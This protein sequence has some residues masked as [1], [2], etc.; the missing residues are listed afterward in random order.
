MHSKTLS[1]PKTL[2]DFVFSVVK[3]NKPGK[4]HINRI[5]FVLNLRNTEGKIRIFTS[6]ATKKTV[7]MVLLYLTSWMFIF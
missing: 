4:G 6:S 1:V 2:L 7:K 3:S 5:R